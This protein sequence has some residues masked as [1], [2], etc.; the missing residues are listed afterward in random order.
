MY[1]PGLMNR[2]PVRPLCI[3]LCKRVRCCAIYTKKKKKSARIIRDAGRPL[4]LA[5]SWKNGMKSSICF[6]HKK[7][8]RRE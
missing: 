7:I 3:V 8:E 2:T 6:T 5:A 1:F 4:L